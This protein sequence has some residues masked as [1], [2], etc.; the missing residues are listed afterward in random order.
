MRNRI[1]RTL[2]TLLSLSLTL[3]SCQNDEEGQAELLLEGN[4]LQV[5]AVFAPRQLGDDTCHAIIGPYYSDNA[6]TFLSHAALYNHQQYSSV[7]TEMMNDYF[8]HK[9]QR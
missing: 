4:E 1:L 8:L 6:R 2:A 9:Q 5:M 7:Y 3:V